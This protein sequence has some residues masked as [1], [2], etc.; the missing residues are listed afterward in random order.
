[1]NLK[2]VSDDLLVIDYTDYHEKYPDNPVPAT[3]VC[4]TMTPDDR[5][6]AFCIL[7]PR[8]LPF[9]AI[10]LEENPA[11]VTTEG[12]QAAKQ[13]ECICRAQRDEGRKW[14]LLIELKYCTKDNIPSNMQNAFDKLDQCYD[15]LCKEKHFFDDAQY[16]VYLCPSHP[17][18]D[19]MKPFGEFIFN[20]D[21]L[22][23]LKDKGAN[24]LYANAV[25]ILTPEYLRKAPS[26]PRRYQ[27]NADS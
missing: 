5:V 6:G 1:M 11:L 26:V 3:G 15:F 23:A 21:R 14:V 7:N 10:N 18:H 24:L 12:G 22:L 25:E 17:E 19:T 4:F 8:H 16:R 13:C 9:E 27:F 20:Q 2:V